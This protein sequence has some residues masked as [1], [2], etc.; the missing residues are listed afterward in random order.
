MPE[1]FALHSISGEVIFP[2]PGPACVR[3]VVVQLDGGTDGGQTWGPGVALVWPN[4]RTAK[5]NLRL[6]DRQ[7]GVYGGD[8]LR[9]TGGPIARERPETVR[10][11]LDT[12][13]VYFQAKTGERWRLIDKQS[14]NGLSGDPVALRLG[15][16]AE[17]G[18]WQDFSGESGAKGQSA[19]RDLRMLG[20]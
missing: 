12:D 13:H 11:I 5:I 7:F 4:G 14:R 19:Y 15:K 18:A 9:I 8:G 10:I 17:N 20:K 3:A 16:L 1:L 2:G 6:E